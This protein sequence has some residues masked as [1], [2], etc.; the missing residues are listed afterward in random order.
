MLFTIVKER[1]NTGL[2]FLLVKLALDF[3]QLFALVFKPADGWVFDQDL[4]YGGRQRF[5]V[6][7][8]TAVAGTGHT[9]LAVAARRCLPELPVTTAPCAICLPDCHASTGSGNG[10]GTFALRTS[11][12]PGYVCA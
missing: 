2:R 5:A 12:R 9:Y 6:V 1:Y 10:F 4:W 3:V 7:Y 11:S 8:R